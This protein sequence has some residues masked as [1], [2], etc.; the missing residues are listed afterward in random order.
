M[1]TVPRVFAYLRRYP[2]MALGTLACAIPSTL[3]VLVS[4][5]VRFEE[6]TD[7]KDEAQFGDRGYRSSAWGQAGDD[8]FEAR[9]TPERVP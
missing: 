4:R 7:N 1:N 6:K 5:S 3:M 2:W 8:L 9:V